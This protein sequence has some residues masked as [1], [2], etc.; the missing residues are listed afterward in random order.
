MLAPETLRG[1]GQKLANELRSKIPVIYASARNAAVAYNWKIKMNETGKIPAFYN[2]IP[3]LNHNEMTGF[4]VS[5]KTKKLSENFHFVFLTDAA[6]HSQIKKRMTVC[7][8]LY[9]NRGLAVTTI[10]LSGDAVFEKI[11]NSLLL[12][13]WA[14]LHTALSYGVS[15]DGVPMV[16]EFKKMIA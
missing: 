8:K 10:A 2:V 14:A 6:D 16:E 5:E 9:E 12:A 11:F 3:E 13:D 1:A 7:K 15:P 4:D